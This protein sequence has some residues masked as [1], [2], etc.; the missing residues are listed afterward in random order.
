MLW[1]SVGSYR[2]KDD[3]TAPTGVGCPAS[4]VKPGVR[5]LT[6]ARPIPTAV[7]CHIGDALTANCH[8]LIVDTGIILTCSAAKVDAALAILDR[9]PVKH[10]VETPFGWQARL[11]VQANHAVP[12]QEGRRSDQAG[13]CQLQPGANRGRGDGMTVY[14]ELGTS[15]IRNS[16]RSGDPM[17]HQLINHWL[18]V[19]VEVA[20][21][22]DLMANTATRK[23]RTCH[24][25]W[26]LTGTVL[27]LRRMHMPNDLLFSHAS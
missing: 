20:S 1:A 14:P 9:R 27:S 21:Q 8:V 22:T 18:L 15:E 10:R 2:P 12:T 25:D 16:N 5:I 17:G 7:L 23:T 24:A 19:P 26:V 13:I 4:W 3:D 11:V 6:N